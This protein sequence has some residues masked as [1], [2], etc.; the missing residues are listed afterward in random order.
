[1]YGNI[2]TLKEIVSIAPYLSGY[3]GLYL[4]G[5]K[6]LY[7]ILADLSILNSKSVPDWIN[8]T[9][10]GIIEYK[11]WS[12]GEMWFKP[13]LKIRSL[14]SNADVHMIPQFYYTYAHKSFKGSHHAL[15]NDG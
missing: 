11:I 8:P 14:R 3:N 15:K 2:R 5:R 10:P 7:N 13:A 6:Q 4:I 9:G 1:M 12:P